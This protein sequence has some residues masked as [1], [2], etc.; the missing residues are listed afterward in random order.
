ME[1]ALSALA[2]AGIG[3]TAAAAGAAVTGLVPVASTVASTAATA[4]TSISALDILS[5]IATAASVLGT[6]TS[7]M[8][9]AGMLDQQASE[10]RIDAGQQQLQ[11]QQRSN[12]LRR[13]L[14]KVLGENDVA[15]AA[16]GIDVGGGIAESSRADATRTANRELTIERRDDDMRR[17][18][19]RAR[20]RGLNRAAGATRGASLL[21]AIGQGADFGIDLVNRG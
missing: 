1:L 6:L 8:S 18:M 16:A 4:A 12:D 2:S 17:A 7:G 5:G 21:K 9:E 3:G 10:A 13:E 19:L 15:F 14:F 20:A 11:S